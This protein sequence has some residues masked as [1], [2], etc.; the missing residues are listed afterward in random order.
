M[1]NDTD[2]TRKIYGKYPGIV[3]D[4]QPPAG[5]GNFQGEIK[6]RVSPIL[7]ENRRPIEVWAKPCFHP[8]FF[9]IPEVDDQV[10]VEFVAGDIDFPIWAGVWYPQGGTP[11]TSDDQAPVTEKKVIRTASGHVVELDDDGGKIVILD[12]NSNQVTLD[13]QGITITDKSNNQ[14]I[15]DSS[16]VKVVDKSG[17][18]VIMQSAGVTVKSNAIKLGSDTAVEPLVLGTQWMT[19]FNTHMHIGNMGGPTSPPGG[20]GT[21]A[22]PAH[23]SAKHMTE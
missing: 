14:I 7:D 8:G 20:A 4:N 21:P 15:M 5:A 1:F 6:V 11:Q 2:T 9:F 16:G 22:T 23:V 19:L 3:V 12:K 18:E 13:D 10:W 17:N